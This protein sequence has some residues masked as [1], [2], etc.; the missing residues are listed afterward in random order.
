MAKLI[1]A[2]LFPGNIQRVRAV[3]QRLMNQLG[4][5]GWY[6]SDGYRLIFGEYPYMEGG[7]YPPASPNDPWKRTFSAFHWKSE[8][9]DTTRKSSIQRPPTRASWHV[10]WWCTSSMRPEYHPTKGL[11][12]AG[13]E[14]YEEADNR[15]YLHFLDGYDPS[16]PLP[17]KLQ[18]GAAFVEF[19][20]WVIGEVSPAQ[21]EQPA[22]SQDAQT[23][24]GGIDHIELLR[25]LTK[26][27]NEGEL[28]TL[29]FGLDI[30][31]DNLP[32]ESKTD[33]ARELIE[34]LARREQTYKLIEVGKRQR[35]DVPWSEVITG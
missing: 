28:R 4:E 2:K 6:S 32:G 25:L 34:Y 7:Y 1:Q 33:K 31:Y 22:S 13:I 5:D 10:L 16:E 27:F 15:T 8:R 19:C 24:V 35:D 17:P 9:D 11:F 29:C 18:I 26:R 30:H 12:S 21:V 20:E 3:M 23:S 14:A